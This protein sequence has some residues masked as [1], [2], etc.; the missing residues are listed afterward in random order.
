[1]G[2][3]VGIERI[4]EVKVRLY[5]G[6][7]ISYVETNGFR[8]RGGDIWD[9]EV[10]KNKYVRGDVK[11][12]VG[13]RGGGKR[14][15]WNGTCGVGCIGGGKREE[16]RSKFMGGNELNNGVSNREFGSRSVTLGAMS[17]IGEIAGDRSS[18]DRKDRA[19]RKQADI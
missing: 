8:E 6:V 10:K 3:R 11:G 1:M 17:A 18:Q 13:L 15:R 9:L 12:G 14:Y 7:G 19:W 5:V 16:I 4:G 2:Y